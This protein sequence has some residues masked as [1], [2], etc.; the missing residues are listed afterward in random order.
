M[1]ITKYIMLLL[2]TTSLLLIPG[3][4]ADK[5]SVNT[6]SVDTMVNITISEAYYADLD[7]D[8]YEDDVFV[9]TQLAFTG[10]SSSYNFDYYI[11]LTLPSGLSYTYSFAASSKVD[12][13]TIGNYFWSHAS[14]AGWYNVDIHIVM[15][16]GG[17]A[18]TSESLIFD[19]PG[20]TGGADPINISFTFY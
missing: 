2:L 16:T 9:E 3:A 6:S 8:G 15:R 18:L 11:V 14:E 7:N 13:L 20:G 17:V 1:K 10:S 19:P 5:N 4:Y 12:F